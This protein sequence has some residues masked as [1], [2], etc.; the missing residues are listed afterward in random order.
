MQAITSVEDDRS[1]WTFR[2]STMPAIPT[3]RNVD[4]LFFTRRRSSMSRT[5]VANLS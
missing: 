3:K 4:H 1:N 2:F 5:P